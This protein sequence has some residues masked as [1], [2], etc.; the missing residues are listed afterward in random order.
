MAMS[1]LINHRG[2]HL[3]SFHELLQAPPCKEETGCHSHSRPSN[4]NGQFAWHSSPLR[5]R[6]GV[7]AIVRHVI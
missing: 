3:V 5:S 4:D 7:F 2:A 6:R 1:T